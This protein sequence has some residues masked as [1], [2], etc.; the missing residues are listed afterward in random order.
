MEKTDDSIVVE[1]VIPASVHQVWKAWTDPNLILGWF[2]SDLNGKGLKADLDVRPG[3]A[4]EVTFQDSDHTMHT[5][6][7]I[8]RDVKEYSTLSFTWMWKS[9][10]G[11]ES[12]VTV[13]LTDEG[14]QTRM[15]FTHAHVG[16]ESAH[17]YLQGWKSTFVKLQRL[18]SPRKSNMKGNDPIITLI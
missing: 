2:G 16:K 9:E 15:V 3:G 10:P 5:C 14:A 13:L 18:L 12:L 8:Y 17:H 11:V 1:I 6:M 4:F 7:G